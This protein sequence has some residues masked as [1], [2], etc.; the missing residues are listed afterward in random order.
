MP[1]IKDWLSNALTDSIVLSSG[2]IADLAGISW[3]YARQTALTFS[4]P[5][6]GLTDGGF[7]IGRSSSLVIETPFNAFVRSDA[8]AFAFERS[9]ITDGL[10]IANANGS[11]LAYGSDLGTSL[12]LSSGSTTVLDMDD[13][14]LSHA[15]SGAFD[16]T[17]FGVNILPGIQYSD[18]LFDGM[19]P[20]INLI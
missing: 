19:F 11:G 2:P 7:G 13:L 17:L 1:I 3:T 8:F 10:N 15:S 14:S 20:D 6:P 16:S 9:G 18:I 4:E 12:S 5:D